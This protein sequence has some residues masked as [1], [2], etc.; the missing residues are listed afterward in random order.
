MRDNTTGT[1]GD[2]DNIYK[3][4]PGNTGEYTEGNLTI[5]TRGSKTKHNT[6]DK[7]LSK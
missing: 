3:P 2:S 4:L 7:G 6:Q 5:E 1:K